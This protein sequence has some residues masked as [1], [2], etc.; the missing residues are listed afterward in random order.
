M[1]FVTCHLWWV[2]GGENNTEIDCAPWTDDV[3]I[4]TSSSEK[5]VHNYVENKILYKMYIS[6]FSYL[7]N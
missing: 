2:T 6:D 4:M 1:L 7:E 5:F 3:T